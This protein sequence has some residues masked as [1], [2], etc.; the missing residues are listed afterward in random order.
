LVDNNENDCPN[1]PDYP[2]PIQDLT[3]TFLDGKIRACGGRPLTEK[4]FELNDSLQSWNEVSSLPMQQYGMKSSLIDDKWFI[5]GG[6]SSETLDTSYTLNQGLFE[7][8]PAI[9]D[10]K[11][12]HCQ[13]TLNSTHIF[14]G[15][16]PRT[17]AFLLDWS[18]QEYEEV[19]GIPNELPY[20]V[21][22]LIENEENGQ[23]IVVARLLYSFIL[24]LATLEWRDGPKLPIPIY[25]AP[26][27]QTNDGFLALGGWDGEY[28]VDTIQRFDGE[29]YEWTVL[30]TREEVAKSYAAAVPVPDDFLKC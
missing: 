10:V 24:N 13:L 29:R 3:A 22:G 6:Y 14:I 5:S 11:N 25:G 16:Y 28:L 4:C 7:P 15:G 9:P 12:L 26:T 19:A 2:F 20:V 8:G 21:C 18:T 17:A 1:L 30:Q 23:E 27:V